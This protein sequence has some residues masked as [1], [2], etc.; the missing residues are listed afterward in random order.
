MAASACARNLVRIALIAGMVLFV[1]V[2]HWIV[3]HQHKHHQG[4]VE[5]DLGTNLALVSD[6]THKNQVNVDTGSKI[7][8]VGNSSSS[9]GTN[10]EG[11][12]GGVDTPHYNETEQKREE[13][14]KLKKI[15]E[16]KHGSYQSFVCSQLINHID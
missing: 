12:R 5:G 6:V 8:N 10:S 14:S 7:A 3:V 15:N 2:V 1:G 16:L 9:S 4:H 13:E 11:S